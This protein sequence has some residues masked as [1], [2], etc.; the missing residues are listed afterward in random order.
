MNLTVESITFDA[1]EPAAVAKFWAFAF[2]AEPVVPSPY[3]AMVE[4]AGRP[5]FL[6]IKVPE[7]KT[8]KNRCHV[9]LHADDEAGVDAEVERL[10]GAGASLV[11]HHRE[12]GTYWATLRDPEG[13][14]FCIG[15]PDLSHGAPA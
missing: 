10:V 1:E 13:N 6:F 2:G 11:D 3:V 8:A 4:S 5:R 12:Y 14:E 9:D 7:S 15:T